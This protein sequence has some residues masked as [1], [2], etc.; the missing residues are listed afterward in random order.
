MNPCHAN[1]QITC[2]QY[3]EKEP[4]IEFVA[5]SEGKIFEVL[6]NTNQIVFTHSGSVT[7]FC[8][9]LSDKK[10]KS[11]ESILIPIQNAA[12]FTALRK[13]T[14]LVMKLD[15]E[16]LTACESFPLKL[17]LNRYEKSREKDDSV[18]VLKYNRHLKNFCNVLADYVKDGIKCSYFY[19]LKIRE[20]LYLIRVYYD[21][22]AVFHFFK[23]VY[24]DDFIFINSVYQNMDKVKT[25]KEL[26]SVLD[27]SMS[28]LE[29]RFHKIFK[30][31]PH[32]WMQQQRAKKIYYEINC[33]KRT[34]SEI[35]FDFGFSSPAHF[36]DFCRIYFNDTP[37]GVRKE[38]EKLSIA[39]FK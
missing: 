3:N 24:N 10:M 32:Q 29:K 27:Y 21:K 5:L 36:N 4:P 16:T 25:I 11:G 30:N 14:L 22:I 12:T 13:T 6:S 19:G 15:F 31:S 34:F 26:A 18:S 38:S 9:A 37:G 2:F 28:G 17:L 23:P 35:A 39:L 33:T 20:F 8:G 7:V 1:E